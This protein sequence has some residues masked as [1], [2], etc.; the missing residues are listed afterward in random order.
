MLSALYFCQLMGQGTVVSF[1]G[2]AAAADT[3]IANPESDFKVCSGTG[4]NT[5]SSIECGPGRVGPGESPHPGDGLRALLQ[6]LLLLLM[7]LLM[8]LFCILAPASLTCV[9]ALAA[10]NVG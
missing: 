5:F 4:C 7:L 2:P 3:A 10:V 1:M 6:Q 8:L 9:P